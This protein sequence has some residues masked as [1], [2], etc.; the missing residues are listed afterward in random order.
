MSNE[1][2]DLMT[3]VN[4]GKIK[5]A[6]AIV[7]AQKAKVKYA[8]DTIRVVKGEAR[9]TKRGKLV[10]QGKDGIWRLKQP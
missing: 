6:L 3:L 7:E 1:F 4:A 8:P 10:E 5:E 9:F 2:A